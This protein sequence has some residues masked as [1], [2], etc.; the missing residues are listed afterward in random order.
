MRYPGGQVFR[1]I[2]CVIICFLPAG[3]GSLFMGGDS[4]WYGQLDKPF[5]TPPGW[6]FGPV[7]TVLY[8]LMAVSL[9]LVWSKG[10]SDRRVKVAV[11]VFMVQLGLNASWTPVFFGGHLILAG[12]VIIILLFAA[13]I[14]TIVFFRKIS[15]SAALLLMPY[16]L[17]VGFAAVLNGAI[18]WLNR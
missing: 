11:G 15:F 1:F 7:W 16:L 2:A 12:L 14:V 13:I 8:F 4:Q 6:V 18:W 17:W 10:L 9:F 5:F 3:I